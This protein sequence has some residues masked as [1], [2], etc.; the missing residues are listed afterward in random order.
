MLAFVKALKK[1]KQRV[2][3]LAE[4]CANFSTAMKQ[5]ST[6]GDGAG[7][8][9]AVSRRNGRGAS[10]RKNAGA[11]WKDRRGGRLSA[12]IG[13]SKRQMDVEEVRPGMKPVGRDPPCR[14]AIRGK[15][16]RATDLEAIVDIAVTRGHIPRRKKGTTDAEKATA[17]EVC[18]EG[19]LVNEEIS[20]RT[21][22]GRIP[23]WGKCGRKAAEKA[24]TRAARISD[25]KWRTPVGV[26]APPLEPT[27]LTPRGR[28]ARRTRARQR[29]TGQR[30]HERSSERN[31][32]TVRREIPGPT[33][34]SRTEESGTRS[35]ACPGSE[36][37]AEEDE[38]NGRARR[39]SVGNA[40][41]GEARDH[42]RPIHSSDAMGGAV[43]GSARQIRIRDAKGG[44]AAGSA[45]QIRIRD[46]KG[47]A[48]AGSARQSR[49]RD[50][51]GGAA[52]GSARQIRIRDVK[53]GAAAGSARPNCT[54]DVKDG[55]MSGP[56]RQIC[57]GSGKEHVMRN[58]SRRTAV[59][60][61]EEEETRGHHR[62]RSIGVRRGGKNGGG[63][64]TR[65]MGKVNAQKGARA[66]GICIRRQDGTS[67]EARLGAGV[68]HIVRNEPRRRGK[69]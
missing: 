8:I 60:S 65:W 45:R 57:A 27:R 2:C 56:P 59:G 9:V 37:D 13:S 36:D 69:E 19:I 18:Q 42:A 24:R 5:K 68:W 28:T 7:S 66:H 34:D 15:R 16:M 20:R 52:A 46:T 38:M 50:A 30:A 47:G 48:V 67:G 11:L 25:A 22:K 32:A 31:A 55:V 62:Q 3:K 12:L 40:E 1:L 44:E 61:V 58:G 64:T 21:A 17:R 49:I 23:P 10:A 39:K 51:K 6:S 33:C 53:G 14:E 29:P 43:A 4:E 35:H 54:R 63:Q 41:Q 26:T